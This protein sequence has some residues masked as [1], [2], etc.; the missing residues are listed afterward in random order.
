MRQP[1]FIQCNVLCHGCM[2]HFVLFSFAAVSLQWNEV[3]WSALMD[4]L[5]LV[6][7]CILLVLGY[8]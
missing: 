6:I 8:Q 5:M 2:S 4:V 1:F 7:F 3:V